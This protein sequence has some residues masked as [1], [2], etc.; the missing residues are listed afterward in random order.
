MC[1]NI[2]QVNMFAGMCESGDWM[3]V[4]VLLSQCLQEDDSVKQCAVL[5]KV[6]I[7]FVF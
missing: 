4:S 3:E 5:K 6:F 2:Y 1:L 7:L